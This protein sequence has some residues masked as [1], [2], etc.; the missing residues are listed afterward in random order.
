MRP[1]A[2]SPSFRPEEIAISSAT[3]AMEFDDSAEHEHDRVIRWRCGEL[4][5]AGY[6]PNNA[7]LLAVNTEVGLTLALELPPAAAPTRNSAANP[8][9]TDRR[10]R[11]PTSWLG[12]AAAHLPK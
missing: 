1:G 6:D 9:L 2:D 12:S 8:L 7:I 10:G 5:R 4:R 11:R 3:A